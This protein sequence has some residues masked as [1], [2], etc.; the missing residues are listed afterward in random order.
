MTTTVV[1]VDDHTML[2]Q[3]LRR[4]LEAEGITVVGEAS[5]G[6]EGV[7]VALATKP[8]VVLMDINLPGM[9]GV[10]VMTSSSRTERSQITVRFRL[11]RDPDSAAADVR[12]KVSR[13]R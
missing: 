5:D 7:K 9:N 13:V 3:G 1:L 4:A 10:E 12:D 11:T 2:R 8:E 6:A